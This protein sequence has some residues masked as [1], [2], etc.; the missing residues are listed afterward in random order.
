[1]SLPFGETS[2][3]CKRNIF[4]QII[5]DGPIITPFKPSPVITE[6]TPVIVDV[7]YYEKVKQFCLTKFGFAVMA[8]LIFFLVQLILQPW[9]IYKNNVVTGLRQINYLTVII[10]SF[11][12]SAL[13]YFL[14]GLFISNMK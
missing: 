14:P 7:S 2:K 1:M 10:V 6:V 8:A 12:G 11:I 3:T 5:N 4:E 13:V 9:Y